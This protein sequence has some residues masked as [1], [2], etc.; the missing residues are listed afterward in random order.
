M[1]NISRSANEFLRGT[2]VS[3]TR[4]SEPLAHWANRFSQE[5]TMRKQMT[6]RLIENSLTSILGPSAKDTT[7]DM[8]GNL[9]L[10]P[11]LQTKIAEVFAQMDED[12]SGS[13]DPSEFASAMRTEFKVQA[14]HEDL[15]QMIEA[16]DTDSN[17]SLELEEFEDVVRDILQKIHEKSSFGPTAEP[18][19]AAPRNEGEKLSAPRPMAPAKPKEMSTKSKASPPRARPMLAA[20]PRLR[21]S[22]PGARACVAHCRVLLPRRPGRRMRDCRRGGRDRACVSTAAFRALPATLGSYEP[23]RAAHWAA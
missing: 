15:I 1:A 16:A 6:W 7:V 4:E 18:V 5:R 19:D 10:G 12:G 3:L 14:S 21:R 13:I 23:R 9:T 17:G 22:I 8:A 2:D 20:R 11:A